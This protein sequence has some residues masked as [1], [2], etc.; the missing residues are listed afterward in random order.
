MMTNAINVQANDRSVCFDAIRAAIEDIVSRL[1]EYVPGYRL[2]AH[3]IMDDGWVTAIIE[4][5]EGQADFLP[6][7][8]GNLDIIASA[9]AAAAERIA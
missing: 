8:S 9:A 4:A 5:E 6:T 7:Y 2:R 1:K 3:P